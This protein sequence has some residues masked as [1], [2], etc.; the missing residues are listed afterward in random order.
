MQETSLLHVV[1]F[2]MAG[3]VDCCH[4]LTLDRGAGDKMLQNKNLEGK[5]LS[6]VWIVFHVLASCCSY[7]YMMT[8]LK[9]K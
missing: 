3:V 5:A 7:F 8:A 2:I 1:F 4:C 6:N 9:R